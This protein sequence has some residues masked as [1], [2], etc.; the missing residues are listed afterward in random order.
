MSWSHALDPI[1]MM[2][3]SPA[4]MLRNST[5]RKMPL[6]S[7]QNDRSVARVSLPGLSVATRKIAARE[8]GATI[9]CVTTRVTLVGLGSI[10]FPP[11]VLYSLAGRVRREMTGRASRTSRE[12]IPRLVT[13]AN[14]YLE[15]R[16]SL[17]AQAAEPQEGTAEKGA[18]VTIRNFFLVKFQA[19]NASACKLSVDEMSK[20]KFSAASHRCE[21]VGDAFSCNIRARGQPATMYGKT[22]FDPARPNSTAPLRNPGSNRPAE[23]PLRASL[24]AGKW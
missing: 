14:K 24:Q 10:V 4:S 8:S 5:A 19:R 11:L 18:S 13:A 22:R 17:A 6:R 3:E 20:A 15:T 23:W 12:G 1:P 16:S 7:P 21:S 9:G 2:Q